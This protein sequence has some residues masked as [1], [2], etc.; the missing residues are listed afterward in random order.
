M[1]IDIVTPTRNRLEYLKENVASVRHSRTYP[2]EVE[3]QHIFHDCGSDDGTADWLKSK[4]LP[5][6]VSPDRVF[7]GLARNQV[8]ET[9]D[10]D[11]IMPLDDD[12]VLLQRTVHH[13]VHALTADDNN[14]S[15]AVADFIKIDQD[16]KYIPGED[17]NGWVFASE[18][19]ML[20][21]I[22]SGNHYIQG[23]VCFRRSLFD[24]VGG[25]SS[26]LKTA[27]DLELYVRFVLEAGLPKYVPAVSHLHRV[28]DK[29][30]SRNVDKD[31][32]NEDM[33]AIYRLHEIELRKRG[34][35]LILI[36]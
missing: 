11:F 5:V 30:I 31:R 29:N 24:Q 3:I 12:D 4:D 35:D 33:E 18:K 16:G 6:L 20:Q 27:E 7:P 1:K 28:H 32:Y 34:V 36:P 14:A 8:L 10:G 17:Y 15:W 26:D 19:E 21:G 23:N 22:F 13:F 25:Y 2:T 9:S